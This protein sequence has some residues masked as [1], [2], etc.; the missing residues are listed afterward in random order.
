MIGLEPSCLFTFRDEAQ[1]LLPGEASDRLANA[2]VLFEE[3][4]AKEQGAGRLTLTLRKSPFR[5]ALLHGHCH[6]KA[7]AA[8]GAVESTL[9]L[10]PALE[11]ETIDSSC[12]GM[13]GAFGYRPEN[14]EISLKMAE[15]SLLP[16]V[17]E[18]GPDT[19]LVADGMS[20]RHQILDGEGHEAVHVARVLESALTEART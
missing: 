10:V 8:M 2:A 11:V 14:Y 18:A 6:Q 1:S 13:A 15:M 5:R 19:I 9:R 3:F 12:C 16:A 4:L 17:R 7:F 20:C